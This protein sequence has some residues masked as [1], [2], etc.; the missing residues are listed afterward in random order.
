MVNDL[1][2]FTAHFATLT[3]DIGLLSDFQFDIE[4]IND[5]PT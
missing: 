4:V 5:R 2:E 3:T 1:V